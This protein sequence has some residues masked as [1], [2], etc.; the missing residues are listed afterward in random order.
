M[1]HSWDGR[2]PNI[3]IWE[4]LTCDGSLTY[5]S[6][7]WSHKQQQLGRIKVIVSHQRSTKAVASDASGGPPS[8][9]GTSLGN[10]MKQRPVWHRPCL[11]FLI[12]RVRPGLRGPG[13]DLTP[14]CL[15]PDLALPRPCLGPSP[16]HDHDTKERNTRDISISFKSL[17]TPPWSGRRARLCTKAGGHDKFDVPL[18][19]AKRTLLS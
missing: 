11:R 13:T 10:V 12:G 7:G 19:A 2:R 18:G 3:N 6:F 4:S 17:K 15:G 14:P 9:Q 5:V 1:C 16:T 8:R